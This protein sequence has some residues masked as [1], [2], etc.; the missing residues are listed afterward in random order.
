MSGGSLTETLHETLSYFGDT[1]TPLTT[2]E[3]ADRLELGRRSTYERLERLVDHGELETKKVGASARVWWQPR[4]SIRN[5]RNRHDEL[6]ITFEDLHG[7]SRALLDA[8]TAE[9]VGE[10]VVSKTTTVLDL[11]GVIVY[12]YDDEQDRLVPGP[13]SVDANFM[14]TEFPVVSLSEE[15]IT[16][17]VFEAGETQLYDDVLESP[18]MQADPA[19]TE[20]RAG[21]FVP[22]EAHGVLVA[23]SRERGSF[24]DEARYLI[25]LLATNAVAAYDRVGRERR[26]DRQRE[27]LAALNNLNDIVRDVTDAIIDRSTRDEIERIVCERLAEA[28]SYEFAWIGDVDSASQTVTLRTEAGVEGYLDDATI[29]VDPDDE[30]SGGP[31]GRALRT[32]EIQTTHDIWNDPRYEPWREVAETYGFRSS[33]AIPIVNGGTVYGVLNV[34][35]DRPHAFEGG[36]G[37]VISQLGEIVGHAI[38]ATER[39]QALMSDEIVELE[40]R[41]H[42]T[43]DDLGIDVGD[44]TDVHITLDHTVALEDETYLV[45]GTAGPNDVDTV[46]RLVETIP[47]WTDVTFRTEG[48]EVT[49]EVRLSKPPVLSTI[50]SI[51][52][53]VDRAVFEDGDY[54]MTLHLSPTVNVRRVIDTVQSTYPAAEMV[55]RRQITRENVDDRVHQVLTSDL[56][57]RQRAT[58]EAAYH[59]GLFEWPRNATGE[60]VADSLEIASPTFHQHLRKAQGKVFES[61]LEQ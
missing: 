51:G 3:V 52:G 5:S 44:P 40:F 42:D 60:E 18:R 34:Y 26:I 58:L 29:S 8:T 1:G 46:E 6:P 13:R 28:E 48:R 20:M 31:T 21:L 45:Y 11:S 35:A 23:G 59:A 27:Q 32:G 19:E 22:M 37:T 55:M 14:R 43:F 33:A 39:K 54:R 49:F 25:E 36:E 38:V 30:H 7:F 50:A 16:G 61:L 24:D 17:H 47:H 15:S 53:T 2:T 9:A 56:T 12:H 10:A 41:I 57:D 4:E